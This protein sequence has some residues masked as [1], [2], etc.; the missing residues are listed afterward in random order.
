MKLSINGT[1]LELP[2]H[3]TAE[4]FEDTNSTHIF[5]GEYG[6][7][8]D[9]ALDSFCKQLNTTRFG[10][11]YKIVFSDQHIFWGGKTPPAGVEILYNVDTAQPKQIRTNHHFMNSVFQNSECETILRNI[12]LLQK[13]ANPE[14]FTPFTWEQYKDFCTHNVSERER[15]VL[16]TFVSGGRSV[17]NTSATQNAGWLSFDEQSGQYSFTEKMVTMLLDRYVW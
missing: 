5:F 1:I 4:Y 9:K 2:E 17:A 10:H 13:N 8:F 11:D 3:C 6:N 12:V 14:R 15:G 7:G 16:N